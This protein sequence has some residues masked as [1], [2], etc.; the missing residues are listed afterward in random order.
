M[1]TDR[2]GRPLAG[3]TRTAP[4]ATAASAACT[5]GTGHTRQSAPTSGPAKTGSPH[6]GAEAGL[7]SL[8]RA[9]RLARRAADL[10]ELGHVIANE[11]R[12]L[13]RARQIFVVSID[14]SH[15]ATVRAVSGIAVVDGASTLAAAVQ[16]LLGRISTE[17]GLASSLAFTLPAWCADE[18][19]LAEAY[20]FIEMAWIPFHDRRR[21]P[22]AGML[23]A[24]ET[25]WTADEI[26]LSERL[27]EGYSQCWRELA[28]PG[29][30]SRTA[31]RLNRWK[32]AATV[33]VLA[34]FALPVPMTVLAP[35]EI[36]ARDA[37][38]VTAPVDGVID[39]V[40]VEPGQS[41]RPG[42]VLVRFVDINARNRHELALRE[43]AVATARVKQLTL[44]SF[45]DAKGRHELG[46]AE[47]ELNLK[48]AELAYAKDT[49]ERTVLRA[50]RAG[51]AVFADRRAMLGRPVATGE[52]L[53]EIAD[54]DR[55]E[56][57]VDVPAVEAAAL[58]PDSA[59]K[60]FLDVDPLHAWHGTV[61]RTDYKARP[62]DADVLSFR[63][64][65][66][67]VA[68]GR[69]PP[70]IGLRGTA[71]VYGDRTALCIYLLR[72][73]LSAARQWLG[74]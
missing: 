17:R 3:A 36:V 37:A 59:I 47:T 25:I 34:G 44:L 56:V 22:I 43:V 12:K 65:A 28:P 6:A 72:R 54:S 10:L 13:N 27:A 33:V 69:P 41:V 53:M 38:L 1:P 50:Q 64:I 42:D 46:L 61:A 66:H 55:I 2:S 23:L 16:R 48:R 11:T 35:A 7:L 30:L 71:Q 21:Q 68:D 24:R 18:R 52:R 60:L 74:L 19:E 40:P 20:P 70:R 62:G 63:T 31:A 57:R 32:L 45:T 4:G 26:T 5:A 29:L 8:M 67:L 9:E 39:A 73:P 49:L 15:G 51:M 14:R 58:K